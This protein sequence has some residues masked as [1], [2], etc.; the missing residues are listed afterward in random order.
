MHLRYKSN[1]SKTNSN[2]RNKINQEK[3]NVNLIILH[4]VKETK[5]DQYYGIEKLLNPK[6][7]YPKSYLNQRQ[8]KT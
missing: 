7:W 1:Y 6:C 2:S 4:Y 8:V 3:C 5:Q